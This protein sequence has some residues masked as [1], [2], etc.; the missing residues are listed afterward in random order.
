MNFT[1]L[2]LIL[3]NGKMD[4]KKKQLLLLS[5]S[6]FFWCD[7]LVGRSVN[8]HEINKARLKYGEF[9]HLYNEKLLKITFAK[10]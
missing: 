2:I 10:M 3:K 8:V 1:F 7:Y 9:H 4:L 5:E 6:S